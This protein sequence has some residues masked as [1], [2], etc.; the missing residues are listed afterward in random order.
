MRQ[1]TSGMTMD[2]SPQSTTKTVNKLERLSQA[3]S[4]AAAVLPS[5]RVGGLVTEVTPAYCRVSGLSH[6]LKL[7]ETVDLSDGQRSQ[8]GEVVRIDEHGATIKPFDA[9]INAGLGMAAWRHGIVAIYP[10]PSWKGRTLNAL[11]NPI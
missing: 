8:L 1:C 4:L 3:L 5:I 2:R 6:F 7:G 10:H 11:G 9:G